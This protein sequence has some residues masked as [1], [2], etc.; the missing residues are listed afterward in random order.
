MKLFEYEAKKVFAKHGIP[1]PEGYTISSPDDVKDVSK[2]VAIK[3][4]V[5]VGGRGKAGGIKF[6][7]NQ[8]EA[9][10]AVSEIIG[11]SIKGI[12]VRQALIEEKL[13]VSKEL[14]LSFMIDRSAR[15]PLLMTSAMG[16]VDIESVPDKEILKI[17]VPPLVGLQPYVIRTLRSKL[18]LDKI[19]SDEIVNT[20]QKMFKL[21]KAEDAELVEV[22]PLVI[23]KDNKV[24]A[25]DAKIT[26]DDNALYR[27]PE[28]QR[29]EQ[30]LTALE[31][32][33]K[34]KGI[35]F[36]QL[37]GDIG[38][39][40]NGAGLTM[41]TLDTLNKKGGKGGTF[42]DLGGTDDPQKVKEAFT[43]L[44]KSNPSVILMNIFGGITKCDTV[45]LGVKE[46][47]EAQP[48]KVPVVARIKGVHEEEAKKILK[49]AGMV[50]VNTMEEAAEEA[51]SLR[52]K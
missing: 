33:A 51:V 26:I 46:A 44:M 16:G 2:P 24:V 10:K 11:M 13:E 34:E 7:M 25:G 14:Y 15:A 50:P 5:L 38:V 20:A 43:L 29:V 18:A 30:D 40:A 6:A 17:H 22:N 45:A 27:H 41:A 12:N 42:L 35:A 28:Y 36:I 1:V 39:I 48:A 49:D 52:G 3:A 9:V 4:Q 19:L 32:E 8:P 21:F 37:D 47:L 31:K 23:T